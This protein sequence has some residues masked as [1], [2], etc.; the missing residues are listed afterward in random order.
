MSGD[1]LASAYEHGFEE[2]LAFFKIAGGPGSGV[3]GNNTKEIDM[4][5]SEHISVGTRK[6]LLD[7]AHYTEREIPM[8]EITH[9]GQSKYVPKKLA[10]MIKKPEI[11]RDIPIC[12]LQVNEHEFHCIDGHH[13]LLA[14]KKLGMKKIKAKVYKKSP[15]TMEKQADFI[16]GGSDEIPARVKKKGFSAS[17]DYM[18][19]KMAREDAEKERTGDHKPW[20]HK[21]ASEPKREYPKTKE[22][23]R[24]DRYKFRD[25]REKAL[26]GTVFLR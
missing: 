25:K 7:N 20:M 9:C 3:S 21:S 2:A 24:E 26:P 23:A 8:S 4:P 6:G 12:V 19:S 14:A 17:I 15:K 13:R 1:M 22:Y 18:K 10:A 5:H 11:V 16:M